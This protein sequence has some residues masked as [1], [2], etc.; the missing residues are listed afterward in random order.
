MTLLSVQAAR[1]TILNQLQPI[2]TETLPLIQC[3]NRALAQDIA[4]ATDLPLFDNSSMDGFAIRSADTVAATANSNVTLS[5]V[6]DIPAGANPQ[7][8]L[9]QGQAAR[10]MTGAPIPKGADAVVPVEDTDFNYRT[11]GTPAPRNCNHFTRCNKERKRSSTR[12]GY[13]P[14]RGR[15]SH[16]P[17]TQVTG[18]RSACHAGHSTSAG[19]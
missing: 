11:A 13:A 10:I 15:Y 3:A 18:S 1:G 9:A 14:G 19:I 7:L 5:V 4:A 12:H 16:R 17:I 8:T 6:A 2:A